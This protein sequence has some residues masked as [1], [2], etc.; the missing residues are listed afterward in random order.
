MLIYNTRPNSIFDSLQKSKPDVSSIC[1]SA[2][3][4]D[5]NDILFFPC[6]K[7]VNSVGIDREWEQVMDFKCLT[8]F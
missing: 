5:I 3:H 8:S 7:N 1:N 2:S 4:N 6:K